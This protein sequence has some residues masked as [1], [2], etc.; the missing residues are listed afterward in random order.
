[1]GQCRGY[2]TS[3]CWIATKKTEPLCSNC[4]LQRDK[5]WF[6]TFLERIAD[7]LAEPSELLSRLED[8][9][10]CMDRPTFL[11]TT[12][13][14]ILVSMMKRNNPTLLK[15]VLDTIRSS[16]QNSI[17]LHRIKFHTPCSNN[18]FC[19]V[20]RYLLCSGTFHEP[21]LPEACL[22]CI[23]ASLTNLSNNVK[24]KQEILRMFRF[25]NIG[26]SQRFAHLLR[27]TVKY[28][29][30]EEIL[31]KFVYCVL[32][33]QAYSSTNER[34]RNL[35]DSLREITEKQFSKEGY[36]AFW[37][38]VYQHPTLLQERIVSKIQEKR[39]D[40]YDYIW[41]HF[42]PIHKELLEVTWNPSRFVEWCLDESI[43]SFLKNEIPDWN[44]TNILL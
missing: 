30:G 15:T 25:A 7:P 22:H 17:L 9:L 1:M 31:T 14:S 13:D 10:P 28:Y 42:L 21:I 32:E 33:Q 43:R 44:S 40:V 38:R 36:D 27:T 4:F 8:L 16:K 11:Y 41:D 26:P 34:I 24:Q 5:D 3:D 29:G 23:G 20:Y 35:F 37:K 18:S 6:K 2:K 12:L 19:S 39:Q